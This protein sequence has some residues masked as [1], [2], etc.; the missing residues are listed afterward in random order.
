M[1]KPVA[2]M[3]AK[4]D[5]LGSNSDIALKNIKWPSLQHARK[6]LKAI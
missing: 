2:H 3:L 6:V 1:A 5:S 4:P